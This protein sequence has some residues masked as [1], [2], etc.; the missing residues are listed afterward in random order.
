[1]KRAAKIVLGLSGL[2]AA[3][4]ATA[5]GAIFVL[6]EDSCRNQILGETPSPDGSLN[7]VIFERDCGATTGF[8]T[9][10]TVLAAGAALPHSGGAVFFVTDDNHG[11][12]PSGPG[13]G[14]EL[15]AHWEG[16]TRLVLQHHSA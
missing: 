12:A 15:R 14:P 7:L 4:V 9:Q 11:A 8:S 6:L 5:A 1:M 10:A 16:P 3:V 13:G 2:A